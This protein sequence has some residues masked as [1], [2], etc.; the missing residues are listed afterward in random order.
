MTRLGTLVAV[1]FVWAAAHHSADPAVVARVLPVE[2]EVSRIAFGSCAFQWAE[3][4]IF[5][6]VV[7]ASPD[8]YISLGDAIYGDFDGERTFEVTP[9]SLRSEWCKLA[10][11]R[12]WKY[13][14]SNVP[15]VATWDNHD[16]GHHSAGAEFPL[17]EVSKDIFLD[18]FGEPAS[19]ERRR[20]PGLYTASIHGPEGRRVQIVLLDTRTFKSPPV[21]AER[22]EGA[23]GS[24]GKYA[25]NMAPAATLLG[26]AQWSWLGEQLSRPAELRL[27]CSSTQVIP[28]EKGMDEWG[29]YPLERGRLFDLVAETGASGVMLLSG[30]VHFAEISA[31]DEGPYR[32]VEF[33][34]SGLTHVNE[35]YPKAPNRYR[36][37]GPFVELNFGLVEIDWEARPGPEI[38]LKAV[39]VDGSTAFE[40]RICLNSLRH[41]GQLGRTER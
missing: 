6:A 22:P 29:N 9:E 39:G 27:L 16:Y 33:T 35:E 1:F 34:S 7:E 25:P 3:Q 4:P 37:A 12:D 38:T 19:S 10:A 30:N 21:L 8:V 14:R 31:T 24:L 20:R 28:D 11:S 5:G 26:E 18:F 15:I 32:I 13:L 40:Y 2:A 17:K 23:G 36:V 41:A